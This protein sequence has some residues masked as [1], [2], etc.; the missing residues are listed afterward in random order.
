[1][2]YKEIGF[3]LLV[4]LLQAILVGAA[5]PQVAL[6]RSEHDFGE[7]QVEDVVQTRF[8][9]SNK[10][11]APLIIDEV[12]TSCGCTAA[13]TQSKEVSPGQNTEIAVSYDSAGLSPGKKTQ[14]VFIHTNG[15][16]DPVSKIQIFANV[17]HPISIEPT[18]LIAKLPHFKDRI[19]FPMTAKNTTGQFIT[20]V[21][22]KVEGAIAKAVLQPDR[23]VV[24]PNSEIRFQIE[25]EL[26]KP[27]KGNFLN[28][29]VSIGVDHPKVSQIALRC[30]IRLGEP[31]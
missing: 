20:L 9:V 25:M 12:R 1:M 7:V 13:V 27:A 28:S 14:S 21:V 5:G 16:N 23:V 8:R 24:Q 18:N 22:S 6:D 19:S 15:G 2:R 17:V 31:K 4:W 11:D 30:L 26:K 10:G 29:A 3:T